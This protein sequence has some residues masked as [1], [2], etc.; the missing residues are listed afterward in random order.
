MVV[1]YALTLLTLLFLKVKTQTCYIS[2]EDYFGSANGKLN[3]DADILYGT[4]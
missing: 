4:A 2:S 1:T 3:S